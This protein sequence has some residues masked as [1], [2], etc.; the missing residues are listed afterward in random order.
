MREHGGTVDAFIG[1][2]VLAFFGAPTAHGD[3]A[4][5]AVA[6][7]VAMQRSM[8]AVNA[9]NREHGLPAIEMGVGLATG[10]AIVG[11]IGSEERAK[12]TVIGRTVNLAA[13]VESY[14]LGGQV[15]LAPST[16]A[17]VAALVDV[18]DERNVHPKGF[19][20]PLRITEV[21]GIRGSYAVAIPENSSD[22]QELTEPIPLR[23]AAL[24]GK[25]VEK[26]THAG[27]LWE[28][29]SGGGIIRSDTPVEEMLDLLVEILDARGEPIPGSCYAKVVDLGPGEGVFTVRFTTRSPALDEK[30]AAL[31]G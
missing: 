25:H 29:A 7:A 14:T 8:G 10:D 26:S 28:L 31:L 22:F 17:E 20:E 12:Y 15:L 3:D 27:S 4:E 1:D 19:E 23:F 21:S 5:R 2:A 11:N 13:R 6:C 9:H 24:D 16:L 30:V 18:A